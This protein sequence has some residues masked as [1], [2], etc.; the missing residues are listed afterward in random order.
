MKN[1][2]LVKEVVD[3]GLSFEWISVGCILFAKMRHC[4]CTLKRLASIVLGILLGSVSFISTQQQY[5][6]QQYQ[7]PH[8]PSILY[9]LFDLIQSNSIHTK[10]IQKHFKTIKNSKKHRSHSQQSSNKAALDNVS[11][12]YHSNIEF[13]ILQNQ[14]SVLISLLP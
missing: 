10:P 3:I 8:Y 9:P 11:R 1:G 2:W 14:N 6:Q 4:T 7:T 12:H 5:T 13:F